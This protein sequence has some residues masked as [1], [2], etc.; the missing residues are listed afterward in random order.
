MSFPK[1]PLIAIGLA[2]SLSWGTPFVFA[3]PPREEAMRLRTQGFAF[4]E[5]GDLA[6][7]RS[8]YEKAIQLDPSYATPHNDLA[9]V[10]E[11]EGK[12]A[13]AEQAYMK[14][15]KL[16]PSYPEA[17][18]NIAM[19]Y[20]RLGDQDKAI[21]HWLKRYQLGD[22]ENAGTLRAKERLQA[23]GAFTKTMQVAEAKGS[24]TKASQTAAKMDKRTSPS[25]TAP[26]GETAQ[27]SGTEPSKAAAMVS[28]T[29]A[30]KLEPKQE[31]NPVL[32]GYMSINEG[33]ETTAI[34]TVRLK[35]A[36]QGI[37]GVDTSKIAKVQFSNDGLSFTTPEPLATTK[38]WLLSTGDGMKIVYAQ[39]LDK[40][41]KPVARL[42]DTITMDTSPLTV[43]V[44]SSR[45]DARERL[46]GQSLDKN[47]QSEREF[48]SV[49]G[50]RAGFPGR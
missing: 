34:P 32:S 24:E 42:Q 37:A 39:L 29:I 14:A 7:A 9:V 26:A 6:N 48:R 30:S 41:E 19:L 27:A 46:I 1:Y 18:A 45:G 47:G 20:E 43:Y 22:P 17:H 49:T 38:P 15:L 28:D 16:N 25:G 8:A 13:E 4:Q 12:F 33:I 36:L 40:D 21:S 10:L 11:E 35:L 3:T 50:E 44:G 23:M 5:Q 2:A 31:V